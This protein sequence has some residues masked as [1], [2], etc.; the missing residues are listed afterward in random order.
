[1]RRVIRWRI[2][3]RNPALNCQRMNKRRDEESEMNLMQSGSLQRHESRTLEGNKYFNQRPLRR[4]LEVVAG[5]RQSQAARPK[6]VKARSSPGSFCSKVC[7]PRPDR[8]LRLSKLSKTT[9]VR[10]CSVPRNDPLGLSEFRFLDGKTYL[11]F[12][13]GQLFINK[14]REKIIIQRRD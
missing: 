7:L 13:S 10:V 8:H 4:Q 6:D 12:A 1:M 14:I 3:C 5:L 2:W 11:L 9:C